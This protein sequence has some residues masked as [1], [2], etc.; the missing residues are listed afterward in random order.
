MSDL[1]E[2]LY[3]NRGGEKYKRPFDDKECVRY[4]AH[5]WNVSPNNSEPFIRQ[6]A[7][8]VPDGTEDAVNRYGPDSVIECHGNSWDHYVIHKQDF[9]KLLQ[10]ARELIRIGGI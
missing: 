7:I 5:D 8:N 2:I 4:S 6:S 10:A 9:I 1:Q 3:V